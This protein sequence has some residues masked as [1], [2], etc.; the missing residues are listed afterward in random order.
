[1]KKS[2]ILIIIALVFGVFSLAHAV[3]Q[4]DVS[5]GQVD[6]TTGQTD[7][8]KDDFHPYIKP[9]MVPPGNPTPK[10]I[11]P[12][13][14]QNAS[15]TPDKRPLLRQE[16]DNKIQNV[17]KNQDT[18][19]INLEARRG[20][21]TST[22]GNI[23]GIKMERND[24]LKD[25]NANAKLELQAMRE[26]GRPGMNSASGT[27]MRKEIMDNARE[28]RKEVRMESRDKIA[29]LRIQKMVHEMRISLNNLKQIRERIN[30]A[31]TNATTNGKD[32][33]E[34]KAALVQADAKI[35]IAE[36]TFISFQALASTTIDMAST[37]PA[38]TAKLQQA[39]KT[40]RDAIQATRQALGDVVRAIAKALRVKLEDNASSTDRVQ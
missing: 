28:G 18:R 36:N 24:E 32:M 20:L 27:P 19:N 16:Y 31:I 34:A 39:S 4:S 29:D 21:A 35:V 25:I 11:L 8:N 40:T 17:K 13:G 14:M 15:G 6:P 23:Q 10:P 33:T 5:T 22:R 30:K 37:T 3:T 38:D 2:S 1:M 9:P 26:D 12:G 7:P